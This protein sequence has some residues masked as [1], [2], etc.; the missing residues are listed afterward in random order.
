[1]DGDKDHYVYELLCYLAL[2]K[3]VTGH[4]R[5][6]LVPRD[7]PKTHKRTAKWPRSPGLKEKH[8][9]FTLHD[10]TGQCQFELCPG[11]KVMDKYGI[12]RAADINLLRGSASPQPTFRDVYGIWDAKYRIKATARIDGP[13]FADFVYTYE[14]MDKPELPAA[15]AGAV[16]LPFRLS[17]LLTNGEFSTEPDNALIARGIQ[18]TAGFPEKP[19]TRPQPS[20]WPVALPAA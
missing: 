4:Y 6:R 13:E 16:G 17:G 11:I 3:Q 15:W 18:E 19:E 1:M 20:H 9:Y 14:V 7:D 2:C 5:I 10:Q 8:S 12:H